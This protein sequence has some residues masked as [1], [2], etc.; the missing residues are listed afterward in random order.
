MK[1]NKIYNY[2]IFIIL[3]LPL[4][5]IP[6]W[7]TPPD[8]GKTI[9]FRSI[10][11]I[12]LFLIAYEFLSQ[13]A[14][15]EKSDP[16][17]IILKNNK[18]VWI[19]LG[20]LGLLLLSSIFSVDSYFSFFGNPI[21]SGG[22]INYVFYIIFAILIFY[23]AKQQD[24]KKYFDFSILIGG[25]VSLVAIFQYYGL[26]QGIFSYFPTRPPSTIGNP[27]FLGI[28]LLMLFFPTITLFIKEKSRNYKYFYA[29]SILLFLYAILISGSRAAYLGLTIGGIYFLLFNPKKLRALKITAIT[30]MIIAGGIIYYANA[31]THFP[32]FLENN[33]LFQS[34]QPRLSVKFFLED[35]RFPAWKIGF[36]A[37][38]EKPILGWGL[39][40]YAVGFNKN[41]DPSL[42]QNKW[43][44]KAHNTFLEIANTAGAPA[45]ILY[46]L[47]F[48]VLFWQLSRS[49]VE[50]LRITDFENLKKHGIKSTLI[51]YLVANFFSIDSFSSYLIFFMLVGY[52]MHLIY[53]TDDKTESQQL[54]QRQPL[55][56]LTG[57]KKTVLGGVFILM[58]WFLWQYNFVPMWVN[59]QINTAQN[60]VT[61]KKC[62]KAFAIMDE[63]VKN[64]SFLDSWVRLRYIDFIG[65]CS[66]LYP[67]NSLTYSKKGVEIEKELI[68]LQP[69]Y[70][71]SWIFL[72][73]FTA[74]VANNETDPATKNSL[75]SDS[76]SYLD[77]AQTLAPNHAEIMSERMRTDMIAGNYQKMTESANLCI[78]NYPD[79]S[80]C[81]WLRALA[82]IHLKDFGEAKK[83]IQIAT[84]KN[85]NAENALSLSQLINAYLDVE[86]Y[87]E[88]VPLYQKLIALNYQLPQHHSSLAVVYAKLGQYKKA[89]EEALIV[90]QLVPEKKAEVNAFIKSLGY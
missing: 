79:F 59:S 71:R 89:R 65:S 39:E 25:L 56:H 35:E 78:K 5:S 66:N 67:E 75:I 27:I 44:D 14:H 6:T 83:D 46:L 72:G 43:W 57:Y 30:L 2:G 4:L 48:V 62:D 41:Y 38:L 88:M 29:G 55:K 22:F 47:L 85:F 18:I 90:S 10:L 68:V 26:F 40:N 49:D 50:R 24:W 81:Y 77:K 15:K 7:F 19:L 3:T 8:F 36:N 60:R 28:Y 9:I 37:F 63:L 21:R 51:A 69:L 74:I 70:V 20:F 84:D 17:P 16:V 61:Y 32:S 11:A 64:H 73:Q 45:L 34:V 58:M 82:K 12:F 76:Y 53:S 87:S 52:S 54:I 13:P 80:T 86:N 31:N 33:K 23:Y 42:V 1:I